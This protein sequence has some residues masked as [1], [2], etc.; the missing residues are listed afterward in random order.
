MG[1]KD[2]RMDARIAKSPGFAK[3]ILTHL[4][5][6]AHQA[7]PD[8]EE[9]LKWGM[10]H[11]TYHENILFGMGS[12]KA[13]VWATILLACPRVTSAP[14]WNVASHSSDGEALAAAFT[15]NLGGA[16]SVRLSFDGAGVD[17]KA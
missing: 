16:G 1:K 12:F 4:R 3:P 6:L 9:T 11:F 14:G 17:I 10:P 8:A 7:C 13:A 15:F 5:K 2:P